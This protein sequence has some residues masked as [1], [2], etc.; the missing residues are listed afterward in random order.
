MTA[1]DGA[2]ARLQRAAELI[3]SRAYV[4]A[5]GAVFVFSD[6]PGVAGYETDGE[7][8]TCADATVG[9]AARNGQKCK[10]ALAGAAVL[11][12]R[13]IIARRPDVAR[14]IAEVAA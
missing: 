2:A 14:Q 3:A 5:G 8:C 6:Q 13:D 9:W 11:A 1:Q 7:R 12:A 4:V 10:H